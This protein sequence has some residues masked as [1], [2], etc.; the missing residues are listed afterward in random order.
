MV[1]TGSLAR[2]DVVPCA[3]ETVEP[4]RQKLVDDGILMRKEGELRFAQDHK[5]RSVRGAAS[6]VLGRPADG[7]I[8][9]K[10]NG[11]P[12]DEIIRGCGQR[13]NKILSTS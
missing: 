3:K 8:E 13:I 10:D 5:F 12:L 7:W 2:P 1:R 9:W 4:V 6:V 11:K